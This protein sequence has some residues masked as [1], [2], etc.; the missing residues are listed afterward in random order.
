MYQPEIFS[1]LVNILLIR[2]NLK[3]L[4]ISVIKAKSE[5]ATYIVLFTNVLAIKN[6]Q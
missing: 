1:F 5:V 6:F 3:I 4:K 2:Q